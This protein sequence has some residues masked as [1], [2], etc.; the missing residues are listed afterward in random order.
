MKNKL[1]DIFPY[2]GDIEFLRVRFVE[3]QDMTDL[4]IICDNSKNHDLEIT[5]SNNF[6]SFK[7]KVI[8]LK[9]FDYIGDLDF[10]FSILDKLDLDYQDIISLSKKETIPPMKLEY[11]LDTYLYF[12][13]HISISKLYNLNQVELNGAQEYGSLLLFFHQLKSN[14]VDNFT[15]LKNFLIN[16][17]YPRPYFTELLGGKIIKKSDNLKPTTNLFSFI[18]NN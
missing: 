5:I 7:D 14:K 17:D 11:G 3:S 6:N 13:P 15:K 9:D 8:I 4:Y 12:G 10:L 2:D 16:G 18:K 1:I